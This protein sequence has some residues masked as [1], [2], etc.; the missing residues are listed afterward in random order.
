LIE[1]SSRLNNLM[2]ESHT[3]SQTIQAAIYSRRQLRYPS[4]ANP[5]ALLIL[6]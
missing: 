6:T 3:K 1:V 2:R 4:M 5:T